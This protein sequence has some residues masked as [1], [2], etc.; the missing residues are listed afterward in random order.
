[1]RDAT[2]NTL[3]DRRMLIASA[4]WPSLMPFPFLHP[5]TPSKLALLSL[6]C[7]PFP[8][9]HSSPPNRFVWT[10]LH[11]TLSFE[12]SCGALRPVQKG[13]CR[14]NIFHQQSEFETP[15]EESFRYIRTQ[16]LTCKTALA[17][18]C[19]LGDSSSH[20]IRNMRVLANTWIRLSILW[21][22]DSAVIM[23]RYRCVVNPRYSKIPR[24]GNCLR[25]RQYVFRN[26]DDLFSV[27]CSWDRNELRINRGFEYSEFVITRVYCVSKLPGFNERPLALDIIYL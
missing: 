7:M 1:M 27:H 16:S 8:F 4:E 15:L 11:I 5:Q 18:N 3:N 24:T 19:T 25:Y 12:A 14:H 26:G 23:V 9:T 13:S 10:C 17:Y 21:M 22:N 6:Q 2:I 20:F